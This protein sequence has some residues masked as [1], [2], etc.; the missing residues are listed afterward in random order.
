LKYTNV[1]SKI[2]TYIIAISSKKKDVTVQLLRKLAIIITI[3]IFCVSTISQEVAAAD[4][5]I[6]VY[7]IG[8][9][10]VDN[11]A[12]DTNFGDSIFL[13]AH[14]YSVSVAEAGGATN[15]E[16]HLIGPKAN[17]WLKFDLS[18][19]PQQA[20]IES[21]VLRMHTAYWGTRSHNKVGVFLGEDASWDESKI[22]WNNAPQ[23]A[24]QNALQIVSVNDPDADY[25]FSLSPSLAQKTTLSL[26]LVSVDSAKEPA[27]FNSRDLENGPM[28]IIGYM[29]GSDNS[30]FEIAVVVIIAT[31]VAATF[32][33]FRIRRRG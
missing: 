16:T 31:I 3:V 8:S 11:S 6:T 1:I 14:N 9:S 7:S 5:E 15:D 26:V 33:F 30:L 20:T 27:V 13:F 12:P 10:F 29:N 17:T 4:R 21:I 2:I 19:I 32:V 25:D 22:S 23:L 24:N 18:N 28:L